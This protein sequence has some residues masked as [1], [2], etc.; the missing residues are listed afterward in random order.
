MK[1]FEVTFCLAFT[2]IFAIASGPTPHTV[3]AAIRKHHL[4]G[5]VP[6]THTVEVDG[7]TTGSAAISLAAGGADPGANLYPRKAQPTDPTFTYP[8]FPKDALYQYLKLN[9]EN[10]VG[11]VVN[12]EARSDWVTDTLDNT[13]PGSVIGSI[14]YGINVTPNL[15]DNDP[16]NDMQ[17]GVY[18]P[19]SSTPRKR[20]HWAGLR[21]VDGVGN[22]DQNVFGAGGKENDVSTWKVGP[23]SVGSAKDDITQAYVA[24]SSYRT[25]DLVNYPSGIKSALMF[26]VERR[27]NN[28]TTAYDIEINQKPANNNNL[29]PNRS[30]GDIL[31]GVQLAAYGTTPAPPVFAISIWDGL[32][33]VPFAISTLPAALRPVVTTNLVQTPSEPWGFVNAKGVWQVGQIPPTC[34]AEVYI[35]ISPQ[36]TL[37][38]TASANTTDPLF[39]QIRTRSSLTDTSDLKDLTT[40]F[41][42]EFTGPTPVLNLRSTC[43]QGLT[44]FPDWGN[45]SGNG[46]TY[47]W[48]I[49]CDPGCTLTSQDPEFGFDPD[50]PGDATRFA[51]TFTNT[52]P[53]ML[54]AI[55][56]PGVNF[57]D[58]DVYLTISPGT[59]T[60]EMLFDVIRVYRALAIAP[61]LTASASGPHTF[62][63]AAN[64]VGGLAPYTFAWTFYDSLGNVIGGSTLENGS[65]DVQKSGTYSASLTVV[66]TGTLDK[67]VCTVTAASNN[68]TFGGKPR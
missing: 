31:V 29:I 47:D 55:L 6:V 43:N 42:L 3:K 9:V 68:I 2:A 56:P 66:D 7:S 5:W 41:P 32:K 22:F 38:N 18:D 14:A 16:T 37:L 65:F 27:A 51:A 15:S 64:R 8:L 1:R 57:T 39:M 54:Q 10:L 60:E 40:Y 58:L 35:P 48:E 52:S 26:A 61:T 11:P 63:F 50:A 36:L 12:D 21:I 46:L 59:S 44:Y 23:G 30:V 17:T 53:H 24:E 28:G 33:Y 4:G 34:L 25:T 19:T 13:T 62:N 67:D 45:G 20:G 49:G